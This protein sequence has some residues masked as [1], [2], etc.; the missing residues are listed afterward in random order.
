MANDFEDRIRRAVQTEQKQI[1]NRSDQEHQRDEAIDRGLSAA[2]AYA[3]AIIGEIVKPR[4]YAARR[5]LPGQSAVSVSADESS[6]SATLRAAVRAGPIACVQIVVRFDHTDS[7]S[8]QASL[9][10]PNGDDGRRIDPEESRV[11]PFKVAD[12]E[13]PSI[14]KWVDDQLV[15]LVPELLRACS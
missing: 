15:S 14:E 9:M 3:G 2:S 13:R 10:R 11:Q 12:G 1:S 8:L 7:V 6:R 4:M 5:A